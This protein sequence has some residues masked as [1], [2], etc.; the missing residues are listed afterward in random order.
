MSILG[1]A[2]SSL[3]IGG[4]VA[5]LVPG[6]VSDIFNY[7]SNK[8]DRESAQDINSANIAAQKEINA[9]NLAYQREVNT[10]NQANTEK[11]WLRDDTATQRKVADLQAAGINKYLAAG[12]GATTS[13]PVKL[14]STTLQAP[15]SEFLPHRAKVNFSAAVGDAINAYKAGLEYENYKVAKKQAEQM[16]DTSKSQSD[17][18]SSD[19]MLN[20]AHIDTAKLEQLKKQAEIQKIQAETDS[21][22]LDNEMWRGGGKKSSGY[23]KTYNDIKTTAKEIYN[24]VHKKPFNLRS[25]FGI[26][27]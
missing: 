26:K 14:E 6:V 19:T 17:K 18:F 15:R 24:F 11:N 7:Q 20:L 2:L 9:Q 25:M 21:L 16:I 4:A 8:K 10:Q 27:G 22:N 3:G 13:M 1:G 23:G 5:S 12:Q